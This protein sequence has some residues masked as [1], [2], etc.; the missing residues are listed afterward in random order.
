MSKAAAHPLGLLSTATQWRR[1]AETA[2]HEET[3]LRL[4][5]GKPVI[6][7]QKAQQQQTQTPDETKPET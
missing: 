7:G 1:M 5:A 3:A 4:I 6:Q 2:A